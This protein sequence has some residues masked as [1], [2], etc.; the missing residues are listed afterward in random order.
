LF[1]FVDSANNPHLCA[2]GDMSSLTP[3]Q[4]RLRKVIWPRITGAKLP[5]MT[6]LGKVT[7]PYPR[8]NKENSRSDSTPPITVFGKAQKEAAHPPAKRRQPQP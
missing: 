3:L 5:F 6:V 7:R 2:I 4:L 1:S 8:R